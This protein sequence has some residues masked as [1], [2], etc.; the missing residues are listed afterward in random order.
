VVHFDSEV[1]A[2]TDAHTTDFTNGFLV[3]ANLDTPGIA[4][5]SIAGT[6]GMTGGLGGLVTIK[7]VVNSALSVPDTVFSSPLRMES[8][9]LYDENG[10]PLPSTTRDGLFLLGS[11]RGDVNG[12]G[13][14]NSADAILALRIAAGLLHPTP[15]QFAAA[16][17]DGNGQVESLDASCILRRAVGLDCLIGGHSL[18]AA[19]LEFAPFSTNADNEVE[20]QVVVNGIDKILSGDVTLQF[21]ASALEVIEIRPS[22]DMVGVAF[23]ANLTNSGQATFS[24]TSTDGFQ[25]QALAVV[26]MRAKTQIDEKNLR[27]AA[28]TLFDDQG[29]RWNGVLTA[30]KE[31]QPT[32]LPMA[33]RLEQNYPN[34][35]YRERAASGAFGS[36]VDPRLAKTNIIYSLPQDEHVRLVI[37][38]LQGRQVRTLEDA[39]KTVGQYVQTWDGLDDSGNPVAASVYVYRL[40]VGRNALS[41][42]LLLLE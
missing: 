32:H 33:F 2:A 26:R 17:F 37:Y 35:F 7:M 31:P 34:P 21:E 3:A 24:F 23:V 39:T 22:T 27:L 29:Q 16:D 36:S 25:S 4:R 6:H 15:E 19:N 28:A 12:D 20:T 38:D 40:Q 42:K 11:N 18:L 9:A 41:R 30:V 8:A 14:I 10:Q 1:L 13:L 5:L